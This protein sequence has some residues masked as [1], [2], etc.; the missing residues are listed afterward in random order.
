MLCCLGEQL[1]T[2]KIIKYTSLDIDRVNIQW[3][4]CKTPLTDD[5]ILGLDI[6]DTLGAAINLSSPTL[7]IN[8]KVIDA[9][10]A[11]G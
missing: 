8:N 5:V 7:T 10:C 2:G 9:A 1:I 3:D 11:N 6:L 4:V